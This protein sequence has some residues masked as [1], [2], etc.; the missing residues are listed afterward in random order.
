MELVKGFTAEAVSRNSVGVASEG[1][2]PAV[3]IED[4]VR[5]MNFSE[6]ENAYGEE[7]L[8]I[9]IWFRAAKRD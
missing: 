2:T 8:T 3:G 1:A 7:K 4:E 5:E 9:R 6:G